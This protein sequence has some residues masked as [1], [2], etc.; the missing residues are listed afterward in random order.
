MDLINEKNQ[1]TNN[2]ISM[3][4]MT[5][6]YYINELKYCLCFEKKLS[7]LYTE[8]KGFL[9]LYCV[10]EE[11]GLACHSIDYF[12]IKSIY[13]SWGESQNNEDRYTQSSAVISSLACYVGMT[14]AF[15]EYSLQYQQ[16]LYQ[17]GHSGLK[18]NSL[19]LQDEQDYCLI[20]ETRILEDTRNLL[21]DYCVALDN[22]NGSD[23]EV[24]SVQI[25][26][27]K[28][29]HQ[30]NENIVKTLINMGYQR[31]YWS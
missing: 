15:I 10:S 27:E 8:E 23:K 22:K 20:R 31:E 1:R 17:F 21:M 6:P 28:T 26:L 18:N 5:L 30:L 3:P 2:D 25:T 19:F 7:E 24:H 29:L 13:E 16:E 9:S 12:N 14:Q 11:I 4:W